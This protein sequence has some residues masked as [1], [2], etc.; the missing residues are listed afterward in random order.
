MEPSI[1][2]QQALSAATRKRKIE[3][4][5]KNCN[6]ESL[7]K[8]QERLAEVKH[9]VENIPTTVDIIGDNLHP[10]QEVDEEDVDREERAILSLSNL[11]DNLI[12]QL[13]NFAKDQNYT[14]KKYMGETTQRSKKQKQFA[15]KHVDSANYQRKE[16]EAEI[17]KDKKKHVGVGQS[18]ITAV[19]LEKLLMIAMQ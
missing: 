2:K 17:K 15:Q 16:T 18:K 11:T 1:G 12:E 4:G 10:Q 3:H 6:N 8:I 14:V 5:Y 9:L 19:E 13:C 7:K